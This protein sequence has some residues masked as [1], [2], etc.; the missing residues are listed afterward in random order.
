MKIGDQN[1]FTIPVGQTVPFRLPA[2]APGTYQI[3]VKAIDKS[4]N[5]R[6]EKTELTIVSIASPVITFCPEAY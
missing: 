2:Q 4:G 5:I 6:E 1:P 3:T